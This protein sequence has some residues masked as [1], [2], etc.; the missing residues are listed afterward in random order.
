MMNSQ[1]DKYILKNGAVILGE[2]IAN[3]ASAAFDLMLP[4]GASLLPKRC[5]GA[6]EVI[7][8]WIFRGAGTR[9]SRQL[10]D[11]LDSLGLHRNS[12]VGSA[13]LVLGAAMESGTLS[14]AMDIFADIILRPS[15]NKEQFELSRQLALQELLG[16]EDDPRQKVMLKLQ[17]HFYP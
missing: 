11:A 3:V 15:L 1:L 7:A 9:D 6:A 16:L 12:S 17:E 13:H 2:Q 10:S 14:A 8:D 5:G 4:C